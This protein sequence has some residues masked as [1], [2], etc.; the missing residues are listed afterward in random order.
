MSDST[1]SAALHVEALY[2]SVEVTPV[3]VSVIITLLAFPVH[4]PELEL[5]PEAIY[6]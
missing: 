6:H 1:Q 2:N 3:D 5:R 4:K